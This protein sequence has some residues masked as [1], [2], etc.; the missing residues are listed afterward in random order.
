MADDEA[1]EIIGEV[2]QMIPPYEGGL[3]RNT[4]RTLG[5]FGIS[6]AS[7]GT[8]QDTMAHPFLI[9]MSLPMNANNT[10]QSR[11]RRTQRN[12]GMSAI[13][14][15]LLSTVQDT[16]GPTAVQI[17]Q[18]LLVSRQVPGI[19]MDLLGGLASRSARSSR[20]ARSADSRSSALRGFEPL[21][22]SQRWEIEARMLYG[23]S[24]LS[25]LLRLQDHAAISMLPA[26]IAA[27]EA[28]AKRELE[29]REQEERRE[30][31]AQESA[32]AAELAGSTEPSEEVAEVPVSDT[33][34]A[35]AAASNLAPHPEATPETTIG[36][37][38][39]ASLADEPMPPS[40]VP[41]TS[42]ADTEMDDAM[43]AEIGPSTEAQAMPEPE[44]APVAPEE[45]PRIM[46]MIHG[47]AVD[48][49]D[50]GVDPTFLEALPDDMREEVL[51]QHMRDQ[52]A[53]R[54]ERPADSQISEEFLDALPPELR[55]EIIQQENMERAARAPPPPVAPPVPGDAPIAQ[56]LDP[57][58]FIASL[59]PSLRQVVLLDQDEGFI[60]SL[61]SHMVAE[62]QMY[63]ETFRRPASSIIP[64]SR[65][66][67][68]PPPAPKV[69]NPRESIQL[70]DKSS[71]AS[72][73]RLLFFPQA[74]KKSVLLK[75]LVN[76][77][78][79]GRTREELLTLLTNVLQDGTGD[80]TAIDKSFAQ[81]S[82]RN[83]KNGT[84]QTPKSIGK[85]RSNADSLSGLG[86]S[87]QEAIPE[88]IAQRCL[89]ALS[90]IV[91]ANESSAIFYL[92]EHEV[93]A[94]RRFASKK[95]KGKEKE[96]QAPPTY[97]PIV[98]LLS[99]L[100][101]RAL[102]KTPS[103]M[104]AAV[105]LLAVVT[106][107]LSSLA[108]KTD[109]GEKAATLPE[110]SGSPAEPSTSDATPVTG[111]ETIAS[112][113]TFSLAVVINSHS[114]P[115]VVAS[116]S[117]PPQPGPTQAEQRSDN[118]PNVAVTAENG[119]KPLLTTPPQIP[120]AVLRLVVNVLTMGECSGR[121]F[122]QT[123][124][125]IQH[126]SYLPDSRDAV[127]SELR[128]KAQESGQVIQ[129][130]LRELS[131]ELAGT[132]SDVPV[133]SAITRF[134]LATSEQAKL[135]RVLKTIDYM[136]TPRVPEQSKDKDQDTLAVQMIYEGF[137]FSPLWAR[138]GDCL[139][140]IEDKPDLEHVATVL[141]PLIE[142]LMVVCKHV[143]TTSVGSAQTILASASPR[144]PTTPRE[145]MENLFVTFT[146]AHRKVLNLMVRNNPSLMSGSFSLL[147][148]NPRVLDFDNKRNYFGLQL[149]RRAGDRQHGGTLQLSVRRERVF[150]DSFQ[151][152]Q[153]KTGE[154]IKNGK[155][156][157]RFYN[158]EGV[159]AGGLTREWFQI[160][161]RQMFNPDYAL[162]QPC[163]GDKL[164]YQP[165]RASWVNPEHLSFFK[166]VGRVI[167]K[168]IYDGRLLDAYFARSFYRQ[169][170]G[171]SVD[172]RD[173][174]WVDPEY[175][176]SL[177]WILENDPEVLD[178]TFSVEADEVRKRSTRVWFLGADFGNSLA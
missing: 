150:E 13:H 146:D 70:L 45:Q 15:E 162:F 57:A 102:L 39:G 36:D 54:I 87:Q 59:E 46:V 129:E 136:F 106:R 40:S 125:L 76:L 158:E 80:V 3:I 131:T 138:L 63:R 69:V 151:Y 35:E 74:I 17:F 4:R 27:A 68:R 161:A 44:T 89:E 137:R 171:K 166:F 22:T 144:A 93:P 168:A 110:T 113:Q 107:P 109:D 28:T 132:Q 11:S 10:N 90:F 99:L 111:T 7:Q 41:L 78:E 67:P 50:T 51:N 83:S 149:R 25:R 103:I 141:L 58:S 174:E 159:D 121:T 148:T 61:P 126:L 157:I 71:V 21:M 81:L 38:P 32:R 34:A 84:P 145:S 20:A 86:L 65:D 178:L 165:N 5:P 177:C 95:G 2:P 55:A 176:N 124:S 33:P 73:A 104:E 85:Q 8:A 30:K 75:S 43:A 14:Q 115:G 94:S 16:L 116:S 9:D 128:E 127:S 79:N 82:F 29:A 24:A 42:D 118:D 170:L 153:R 88:L 48:I 122:Q 164:T 100:D 139:T 26:S 98:S 147:V 56:E 156:S 62:A 119:P 160:L 123:L 60:R 154:Q 173:V 133:S 66:S 18:R 64:S 175:Y 53:A 140:V 49:T 101:R 6:P 169:L 37:V 23:R 117:A 108:A 77:C 19:P 120:P 167:G 155:L 96:K 130:D 134:S 114:C 135:L 152:L 91:G 72:L 47:S 142:S 92:T 12:D 172:Y 97:Y 31:E 105:G 1:Y 52:R 163:V 143:G 112:G